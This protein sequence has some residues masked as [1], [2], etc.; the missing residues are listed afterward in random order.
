MIKLFSLNRLHPH[1]LP[2]GGRGAAHHANY[3]KFFDGHLLDEIGISLSFKTEVKEDFI[4]P[5]KRP[6]ELPEFF[7]KDHSSSHLVKRK[8]SS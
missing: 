5:S 7:V 1:P 2:E 3:I 8:L 6:H 4:S